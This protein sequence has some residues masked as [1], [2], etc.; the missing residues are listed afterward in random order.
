M[1]APIRDMTKG[2]PARLILFFALPLMLGNVFQQL[3][4][5]VDTIVVGQV[6]GVQALAALGAVEWIM[7]MVLGVSTGITQGFSILIAQHYGAQ[8]WNDLKKAVAHSYALTAITALLL[9]II[10]QLSA[11]WLLVLLN[12]PDNIIHMSLTYLRIVFLGI[13]AV[14]AYNI[15]ASVLRALGN[16]RSPLIAMVIASVIN[17]VLDLLFVAVLHYGVGGAALA[18]I[19]A[20]LFSALYCFLTVR[21]IKI[22][23][24]TKQDFQK[25]PGL[26]LQLFKLGAPILFQD[27]IIS[28]GGFAV[29]F[30]VNS[31]GFLFVA[32]FTA[33]N[34]LYGIL[35]MAAISYGYAIV[36]YVGQNLGAGQLER[37]RKG[38]RSGAILAFF[39]SALISALMFIFGR[40]ILKLFI[41]GDAS[42]TSQVLAIAWHYLCIMASCLCILYFLHVYR[43][44]LQ[45][46]GNTFIPMFSG[47]TEFF[48]RVGV[49]LFLPH[50]I[51]QNG[52][53]YAEIA[54]W[55]GAAVLLFFSYYYKIHKIIKPVS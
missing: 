49:A 27:F 37:I 12:T 26:N 9:L 42:Q 35:E 15:F 14:A 44:A 52:I 40:H 7:W 47:I 45:G 46:L 10:S 18:T 41:S 51:G 48:I 3:Y 20:Q 23:Q 30:V 33:T 34:K 11:H 31:Y 22:V 8:K 29:Q 39:T 54:A 28:V 36:T 16:S 1:S 53:F 50:L 2:S 4:T 25:I 19:T 6:A 17:I 24:I 32:G 38:V 13:P 55:T 21:K 43:S 5:M